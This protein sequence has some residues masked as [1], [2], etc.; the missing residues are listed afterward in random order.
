MTAFTDGST[1]YK[2]MNGTRSRNQCSEGTADN[3]G[4]KENVL[5]ARGGRAYPWRKWRWNDMASLTNDATDADA[6]VAL[7]AL[8]TSGSGS[9]R[10][11]RK[12]SPECEMCPSFRE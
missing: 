12:S 10:G 1:H 11:R 8:A 6:A 9:K 5:D 2:A 4:N 3:E 7:S